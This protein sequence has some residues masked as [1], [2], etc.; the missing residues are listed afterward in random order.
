MDHPKCQRSHFVSAVEDRAYEMTE[1]TLLGN[2][3]DDVLTRFEI[4]HKTE[5]WFS[6]YRDT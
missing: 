6:C 1:I 3:K 2:G 4:R 5:N